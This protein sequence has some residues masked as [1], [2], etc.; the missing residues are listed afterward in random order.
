VRVQSYRPIKQGAPIL[1]NFLGI[2]FGW[3]GTL[4]PQRQTECNKLF[5]SYLFHT[6]RIRDDIDVVA[7]VVQHHRQCAARD[8]DVR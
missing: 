3:D 4:I 8:R 5:S 1:K 6:Q 7:A 2:Y